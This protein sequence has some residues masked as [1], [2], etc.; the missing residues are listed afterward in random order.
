MTRAA[1]RTFSGRENLEERW[2]EDARIDRAI[3]EF[4]R[5]KVKAA[6]S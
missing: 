6:A 3:L 2:F 1:F 4:M 5:R